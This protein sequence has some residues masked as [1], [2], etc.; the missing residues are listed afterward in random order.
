M[1]SY[2][3]SL[4]FLG[5]LM[6]VSATYLGPTGMGLLLW[7]ATSFMVVGTAYLF[8]LRGVFGKRPDGTLAASHVLILAPFLGFTWSVWHLAR[9]LSSERAIDVH[10][11]RLR[12]ARRLLARELPTDV[13]LIIDLTAEFPAC[14]FGPNYQNLRILDGGQPDPIELRHVLERIPREGVTLVHCAQGHG[15]TALFAACLLID[16]D[17]LDAATAV[18]QVLA[19]RPNARMSRIQRAFVDDF[20]A[21]RR[22]GHGGP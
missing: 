11:P 3:P 15:R 2:G 6:G 10:S 9:V 20:A 13:D 19:V 5:L 1:A 4:V 21:R 16:R 22:A 7:M 8:E 17:G 14:N 18:A 12:L